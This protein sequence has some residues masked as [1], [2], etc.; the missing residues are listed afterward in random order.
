VYGTAEFQPG[1]EE[2][3]ESIST[4]TSTSVPAATASYVAPETLIPVAEES[5]TGSPVDNATEA[6]AT[7]S[8]GLSLVQKA[9]FLAVIAGAV[10]VYIRMASRSSSRGAYSRV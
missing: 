1:M 2:I 10:A 8:E 6:V 3:E 4:P 7:D 9:L 5:L